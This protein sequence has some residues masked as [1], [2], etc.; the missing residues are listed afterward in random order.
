MLPSFPL[1]EFARYGMGMNVKLLDASRT[2]SDAQL[3][4]PLDIGMGS[5]RRILR[6]V[7]AGEITWLERWRGVTEAV[8]A[9]ASLPHDLP[10]LSARFDQTGHDLIHFIEA[11][12]PDR[13]AI[14]QP[15]RDSRGT[16]YRATLGQMILQ[17]LLHSH[18]HRAQ[19]VNALRRVGGPVVEVDYMYSVRQT[20]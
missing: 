18:H 2:L 9:E 4:Q 1:V 14:E 10:T 17:G 7:L 3:D 19:W 13:L 5:V 20:A 6:H 11:L 8:W 16:L 12:A 15:Y